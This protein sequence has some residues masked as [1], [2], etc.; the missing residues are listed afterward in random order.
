MAESVS[1]CLLESSRGREGR[2]CLWRM[3]EGEGERVV[4]YTLTKYQTLRSHFAFE[5]AFEYCN[6]IFSKGQYDILCVNYEM[7][8]CVLCINVPVVAVVR[9]QKSFAVIRISY[10]LPVLPVLPH[11]DMIN[12]FK[13][14]TES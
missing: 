1:Q 3:W 11:G 2:L 7:R 6:G 10:V 14:L 9:Q 12:I 5:Y 4:D 8:R 13:V